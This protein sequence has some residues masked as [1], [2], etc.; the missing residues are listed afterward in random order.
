M[1]AQKMRAADS[2]KILL[3]IQKIIHRHI[4]EDLSF[5]MWRERLFI[6]TQMSLLPFG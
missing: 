6:E 4:L 5:D 1:F 2:T 3:T